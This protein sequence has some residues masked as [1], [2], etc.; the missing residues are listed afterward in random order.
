M[1]ALI[2]VGVDYKAHRYPVVT[3]SLMGICTAVY[4]ITLAL[5]LSQGREVYVWTMTHLWLI[6]AESRWWTFIT[7]MFVHAGLLHLVGNMIFLFLFGSCVEDWIG[8]FRFVVFYLL[9]GL[10]ADF[11]YIAFIPAHFASE[12]PMGGASGAISG[13]IGGFVLLLLKTKIEFKWFFFFFFR[14]AS[15]EFFLPA[16]LVVSFWFLRDLASA[17]IAA[18]NP[19]H[20]AGVAFGAHVGGTLCGLGLVAL[21]KLRVNVRPVSIS[22]QTAQLADIYLYLNEAQAG[23]FTL[24]QVRQMLSM[25]SI[26]A[27][28]FYWKEGMEG[29]QSSDELFPPA[30]T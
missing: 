2:P 4:L 29:W 14:L 12:I 10:G 21:E 25:G 8:R 27:G 13:C 7:S 23:P 5:A 19:E 6:P 17:V 1:F 11:A 16:W 20:S 30:Q 28:T 15:G 24:G 18:A 26:P 9:C 22:P 3:F